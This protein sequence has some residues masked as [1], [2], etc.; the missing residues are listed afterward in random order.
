VSQTPSTKLYIVHQTPLIDENGRQHYIS[1]IDLDTLERYGEKLLL[2]MRSGINAIKKFFSDPGLNP[3]KNLE[4]LELAACTLERLA[5]SISTALR[6]FFVM[7]LIPYPLTERITKSAPTPN[8]MLYVWVMCRGSELVKSS[9]E[10]P[11]LISESKID[12]QAINNLVNLVMNS[13][14]EQ[15]IKPPTSED[16]ALE[17]LELLM[18]LP[19]DTRPGCSISKLIPHLITTA[20]L[21]VAK[22][23][24]E[25][26]SLD[27]AAKAIHRIE[28]ALLR[29]AAL[30][31]DVGKPYAWVK[32]FRSGNFVS[33]AHES[34]Q[35]LRALGIYDL[36]RE[37]GLEELFE[38][39]RTLVEKHHNVNE[40]PTKAVAESL[41]IELELRK[42]GTILAE[43]DRDSSNIDRLSEYFAD[44]ARDLI[45]EEAKRLNLDPKALFA[46][47]GPAVWRAWLT[48]PPERLREIAQRI[49]SRIRA[50][51]IDPSLLASSQREVAKGVKLL[52][53]DVAGIQK[54]IRRESLR[55]V[56][57]SSFVIDLLTVY[58]IPRA[59]IEKLG[60]SLDSI[61]Y[62]GGGFVI[63][64]VPATTDNSL[65]REALEHAKKII[66]IDIELNHAL[67]ELERSWPRAL[68]SLTSMLATKKSL[69]KESQRNH[70]LTGYEVLC[71]VCGLRPA[72][73][74]ANESPTRANV[75]DEC[76]ALHEFG[77][78]MY[79]GLRLATLKDYGYQCAEQYLN[80]LKQIYQYLMPWLSGAEPKEA[81]YKQYSIAVVK[82][83]GNAVGQ[84]MASAMNIAE[85][86]CRSIRI[87]MGLK[88]GFV[89]AL[90]KLREELGNEFERLAARIYVGTLYAGGDDLLAIWP[91]AIALPTALVLAKT[92]WRINGGELQLSIAITSAKPKHNV[93]NVLDAASYSLNLCKR[94]YRLTHAES[95]GSAL[96]AVLTV[97]KSE[98]Q[99]F[100]AEVEELL[101]T[102]TTRG[103]SRQPLAVPLSMGSGRTLLCG[104][105]LYLLSR[106][107]ADALGVRIATVDDLV[108]ALLEAYR[109]QRLVNNLIDA[110]HEAMNALS[111]CENWITLAL[112]LARCAQ[113]ARVRGRETSARIYEGL[114]KLCLECRSLPP[115]FDLYHIAQT[116]RLG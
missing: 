101:R 27:E 91:T 12:Y 62:A 84:F 38:A 10:A 72:T 6:R 112:F 88:L 21:A 18:N 1:E 110:I 20:G 66:G 13:L 41:G 3:C 50:R 61:V 33:H 93:W 103:L 54:F 67:T 114:A 30:L 64:L 4:G 37:R 108:S 44:I 47:T 57:A 43:A 99:L 52:A 40:L 11:C 36:L 89:A 28:L 22:Y 65:I 115:L 8:D 23:L 29:L 34:S 19:S 69:A 100:E 116:L 75:C 102:Y 74:R 94:G 79:V 49:A 105:A 106:A 71:E 76:E 39:L 48:I 63:A 56:M 16:E 97:V 53:I 42:L 46:G 68:R 107:L 73:R 78:S 14:G 25:L 15:V 51:V 104:D 58:A 35:L 83:D 81:L 111:S 90:R 32:M 45:A 109:N 55:V 80:E 96:V 17:R 5:D 77:S 7:P 87:D 26:K 86:M 113:R 31:H 59:L 85:A 82:A 92:F 24:T 98:R 70:L 9:L 2:I 95:M 60:I